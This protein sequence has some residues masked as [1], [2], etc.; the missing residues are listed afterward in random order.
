MT[1]FNLDIK[2]LGKTKKISHQDKLGF[3]KL[4]HTL[5]PNSILK[6]YRIN[7]ENFFYKSKNQVLWNPQIKAFIKYNG[8]YLMTYVSA[9]CSTDSLI[10]WKFCR[11]KSVIG[12]NLQGCF[13]YHHR[14]FQINNCCV[15]CPALERCTNPKAGRDTFLGGS[16]QPFL[17][18]S[19]IF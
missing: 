2:L 12:I 6:S 1:I 3:N 19:N 13:F 16:F 10:I 8:T 15:F 5:R 18:I 17:L 11:K 14:H 4:K 9:R 7:L